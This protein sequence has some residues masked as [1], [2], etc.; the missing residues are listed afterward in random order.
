MMGL[1]DFEIYLGNDPRETLELLCDEESP[2]KLSHHDSTYFF[3]PKKWVGN[4]REPLMAYQKPDAELLYLYGEGSLE[5]VASQQL[6]MEPQAVFTYTCSDLSMTDQEKECLSDLLLFFVQ[7]KRH[8]FVKGYTLDHDSSFV[9]GY[10][11]LTNQFYFH[12][13]F[14]TFS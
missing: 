2:L 4:D 6:N 9:G 1:T 5:N 11:P 14:P 8:F 13:D 12:K 10:N 3:K 7:Q